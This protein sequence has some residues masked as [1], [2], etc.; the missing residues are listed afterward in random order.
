MSL[1]RIGV[2]MGGSSS[3]R[4]VSLLTGRAVSEGLRQAGYDVV[5]ID[6]QPEH[7]LA[8]VLQSASIDAAFLALHGDQ[9]ED[10]CVQGLLELLR[11]PYTGSGVLASALAMDKL[12]AKELFRLYNIATPPYYV[13]HRDEVK[14]IATL[15]GGFGFPAVVKP[16]RGGSSLGVTKVDSLGELL[17]A[18]EHA[19]SFDDTV[20][21]ERFVK[22]KEVAVGL[23]QG[24]V[25]GAIEISPAVPLYDYHA[26]YQSRSTRYHLPARL[27][28]TRMSGVLNLAE[29]AAQSL[30]CSGAARVDL[31]V[32]E[33]QNEYV[34]E[35]N[36]LPGMTE[37]SLLPK[38]AA[39]AGY[40]FS[41]LCDAIVRSARL[42]RACSVQPSDAQQRP[43]MT[44]ASVEPAVALAV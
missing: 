44:P 16:R 1:Q 32:T 21:V 11:I 13:V 23:L 38:I 28:S 31:L 7:E 5:T 36:S 33:G 29:R 8:G 10:G 27:D 40:S 15:H 4:E 30:G 14:E 2:I 17:S 39:A 26:K 35:V 43:E 25:L 9:G 42:E 19:L 3:E 20:L 34:I 12:K 6:A 22:A 24:R 37:T 41:E 18:V